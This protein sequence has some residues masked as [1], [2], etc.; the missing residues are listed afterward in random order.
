M[1]RLFYS[2]IA[3]LAFSVSGMA[4][5]IELEKDLFFE[6]EQALFE[7]SVQVENDPTSYWDCLML[8]GR[9]YAELSENFPEEEA[10]DNAMAFYEDCVETVAANNKKKDKELSAE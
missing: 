8:A 7:T 1:K 5:T 9:V 10:I 6:T 3:V 4:N 2:T